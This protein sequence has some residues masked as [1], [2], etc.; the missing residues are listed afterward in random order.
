MVV[1]LLAVLACLP[2]L[3]PSFARAFPHLAPLYPN[4]RAAS[5]VLAQDRGEVGTASGAEIAM[6]EHRICADLGGLER[7]RAGGF[8]GSPI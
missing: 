6:P 1:E 2:G 4:P 7:R 8:W 5:Q 3:V